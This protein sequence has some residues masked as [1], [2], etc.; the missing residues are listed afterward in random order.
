MGDTKPQHPETQETCSAVV[1]GIATTPDPMPSAL[2]L[3][4]EKLAI[5]VWFKND[6]VCR[7]ASE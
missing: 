4:S 3:T 2:N 5:D 1:P 7:L 6:G